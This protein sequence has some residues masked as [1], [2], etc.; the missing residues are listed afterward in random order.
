M[1]AASKNQRGF[2]L[3][4][5]LI[6]IAVLAGLA[7]AL[8]PAAFGSVRAST[9]IVSLSAERE[10]ARVADEALEGIFSNAVVIASDPAALRFQG[11]SHEIS[12]ISLAGPDA[13]PRKFQLKIDN[14]AL[15]AEIVGFAD[16][17]DEPQTTTLLRRGAA[18]FSFYGSPDAAGVASWTSVWNNKIPPRLVRLKVSTPNGRGLPFLEYVV[19]PNGP[20]HCAFDPVSRRCRN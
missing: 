12:L 13:T 5:A 3:T 10:A 2:S 16:R 15:N 19:T 11:R 18:E 1:T 6:A 8:A 17:N 4:E 7:S 20:L 9:E 14:G